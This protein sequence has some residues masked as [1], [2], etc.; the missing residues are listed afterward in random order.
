M[1]SLARDIRN[2][3]ESN[4][5]RDPFDLA[6]Y[7]EA[8][9]RELVADA[10]KEP[11][12]VRQMV[13]FS[14]LVGGGKGSRQK[15]DPACGKHMAAALR[16]LGFEED[17]GASEDLACQ[18]TFKHQHDTD[19]NIMTL[20]IFP[21]VE[22]VEDAAAGE[23]EEEALDWKSLPPEY[24]C[25]VCSVAVFQGLARAK[26]PSWSQK[27]RMLDA[28]REMDTKFGALEE[29]LVAMEPMTA[30][31]QRLYESSSTDNLREKAEWLQGDMKAMV[32]AGQ[33][34]EPEQA[35][36]LAQ[37][38]ERR[39]EV[40]AN[41]EAATA[42]GQE[43]K[44]AKLRGALEGLDERIA[45]LKAVTPVKHKLKH[46]SQIKKLRKELVA[47]DASMDPGR[48]M[49]MEKIQAQLDELEADAAEWFSE[50]DDRMA[51]LARSAEKEAEKAQAEQARRNEGFTVVKKKKK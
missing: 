44:Q 4:D 29:K 3:G 28:L 10:F 12:P 20:H 40:S 49:K 2:A 43:K 51:K 32:D 18:G 11:I 38:T 22:I 14:F 37:A 30:D 25:T 15:Y 6:N 7:N 23:G 31:E 47:V 16:E 5:L 50:G 45:K 34:T 9:L 48:P 26:T 17:R 39:A 36:L 24:L 35:Q 33:L 19:K 46:Q 27:R 21:R 8:R 42:A 13:R 1:S 41:L